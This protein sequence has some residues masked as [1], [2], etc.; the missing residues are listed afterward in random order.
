MVKSNPEMTGS[1]LIHEHKESWFEYYFLFSHDLAVTN[2][3]RT[4]LMAVIEKM[5]PG[6]KSA[7][8]N[9][10]HENG[11]WLRLPRILTAAELYKIMG[12]TGYVQYGGPTLI[13]KRWDQVDENC[14]FQA[15]EYYIRSLSEQDC[16]QVVLHVNTVEGFKDV[17]PYRLPGIIKSRF[18][19][20]KYYFHNLPVPVV[21]R[22]IEATT[23]PRQ[24][25]WSGLSVPITVIDSTRKLNDF[26]RAEGKKLVCLYLF[27][28]FINLDG[29]SKQ[30]RGSEQE[31]V[32]MLIDSPFS[33]KN[34]VHLFD[35][36]KPYW[37]DRITTPPRLVAAGL[38][39]SEIPL[40]VESP[41]A[42]PYRI[43]DPFLGTGT[44]VLEAMKYPVHIVGTELE[45]IEGIQD[46]LDFFLTFT[47]EEIEQFI[48]LIE[49][50]ICNE[51]DPYLSKV[52]RV[53]AL[54]YGG[55]QE[56][57]T[58]LSLNQLLESLKIG[59]NLIPLSTF[60]RDSRR[61]SSTFQEELVALHKDY[62]ATDRFN[63]MLL[64]QVFR[65]LVQWYGQCIFSNYYLDHAL[66]RRVYNAQWGKLDLNHEFAEGY[67]REKLKALCTQVKT[68]ET[69]EGWRDG[70][71]VET[72]FQIPTRLRNGVPYRPYDWDLQR[73]VNLKSWDVK[74]LCKLEPAELAAALGLEPVKSE[75]ELR[76]IDL[77]ITDLPYSMNATVPELEDLYLCFY[78]LCSR[79]LK[80]NGELI[81]FVLDKV[82]SGRHVPDCALREHLVP[83]LEDWFTKHGRRVK[84]CITK[85][86]LGPYD[87][88]LYWKSK[89]ALNR[90]ILHYRIR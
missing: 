67:L 50:R 20:D 51:R 47:S 52:M 7:I 48:K 33:S 43:Y 86:V 66:F 27:Q 59:Q 3:A 22:N 53:L 90:A 57:R 42:K 83:T 41:P 15:I 1:F 35:D 73:R 9:D 17:W 11:M 44:T 78:Q 85:D 39:L 54:L 69:Q 58:D 77:V 24:K 72:I 12:L 30:Y 19:R 71:A 56:C 16:L 38:N 29:S 45:P 40:S 14:L 49:D 6:A 65:I 79:V 75:Q 55:Q 70:L 82:R 68:L 4:E 81:L 63:R 13:R 10:N 89:K 84:S 32:L 31:T 5:L 23:V 28:D 37:P 74:K 36:D 46:N 64:Y 8:A 34:M 62:P 25:P 18:Y 76:Q 2:I 21:L 87:Q 61:E 60:S 26:Q 88:V 80:P